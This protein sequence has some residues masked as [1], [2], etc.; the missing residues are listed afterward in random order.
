MVW[1]VGMVAGIIAD[2]A[3]PA[4]LIGEDTKT[5]VLAGPESVTAKE[6]ENMFSGGRFGL[7]RVVPASFAGGVRHEDD[8][9]ATQGQDTGNFGKLIVV[10]DDDADLRLADV[11]HQDVAAS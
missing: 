3:S 6:L 8:V 7:G 11:E 1:L 4:C 2:V 10:A 5:R 9:S